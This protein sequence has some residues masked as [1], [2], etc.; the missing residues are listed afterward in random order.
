[1]EHVARMPQINTCKIFVGIPQ[2]DYFEEISIDGR[3]VIAQH[4]YY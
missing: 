3:I 2:R 1:V 4:N